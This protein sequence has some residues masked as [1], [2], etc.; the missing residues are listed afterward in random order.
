MPKPLYILCSESGSDDKTTS[1]VSIFNVL[2]Q[3]ELRQAPKTPEGGLQIF[4][5]LSLYVVAAWAATPEDDPEESF[6][7]V[8]SLFLPPKD[9]VIDLLNGTFKFDKPRFRMAA[10]LK[11]VQF[12]GPGIFRAES[13]I[14]RQADGDDAWLVQR[15]DVDVVPVNVDPPSTDGVPLS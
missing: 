3:I 2:E 8:L 6:Q 9:E 4:P 10:V 7:Y 1:M 15:Y 14:K 11:G 12:R 5:G 13:K